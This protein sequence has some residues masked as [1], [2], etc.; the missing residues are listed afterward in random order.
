LSRRKSRRNSAQS[1]AKYY[2]VGGIVIV[3]V[4]GYL[5]A[6][7]SLHELGVTS[8]SSSSTSQSVSTSEASASSKPIIL[9]VNQGNG[10]VNGSNFG[11]LLSTATSQGFNTIFFQIYRSG[12]LLFTSS[13]LAQFVASA[14][15]QGLKFFFALY[16]TNTTQSIPTSIYSDGED[17]ISLDM[18]GLPVAAQSALF[19]QLSSSYSGK[20]AITTTYPSL[21]VSPDLLVVETYAPGDQQYIHP[22]MIGGVEVV[23]TSSQQ[24]Y[25]QQVQ[26]A[27]AHS[28]GVMVFDYAGLVKSGY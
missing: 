23:A 21:P 28:D 2:L 12:T 18:S 27:L 19:D 22:G 7:T 26:Y 16:F 15:D 5:L 10:V 20:T 1:R 25:E 6:S 9:Y 13:S 24:D 4:V 17:G 3:A 14:H 11:E 8:S